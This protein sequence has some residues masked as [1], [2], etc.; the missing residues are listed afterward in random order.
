[1]RFNKSL[2]YSLR[3]YIRTIFR[4][5]E[6]ESIS[7]IE[8][9]HDGLYHSGVIGYCGTHF[10]DINNIISTSSERIIVELCSSKCIYEMFYRI[11]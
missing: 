1:M 2:W 4:L 6:N 7:N 5:L 11:N 10:I 9:A 3:R 8:H